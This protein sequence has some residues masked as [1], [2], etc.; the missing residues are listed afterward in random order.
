MSARILIVDDA[1]FVRDLVRRTVR[2][3]L[4]GVELEEAVNGRK[5]SQLMQGKP[6]DLI[7]CDWEMPEMSGIEL[8]KWA[9]AQPAYRSTPFIMVTSR[10]DKGHVV[11]AVQG[12][13]SDYLGKP[14]SPELLLKKIAKAL[15]PGK[16]ASVSGRAAAAPAAAPASDSAALLTG[17]A[18]V[19]ASAPAAAAQAVTPK[20][21]TLAQIRFAEFHLPCIVKAVSLNEMRVVARNNGQ[22]AFPA[23]LAQAAV[24]IES[25]GAHTVQRLNGYVHALQAVD[26]RL[27]TDFISLTIRFVDE[28]PEKLAALSHFIESF[29]A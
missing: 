1:S 16:M 25:D 21:K 19:P 10:G 4:P 9:R 27:D 15:G 7:L 3:Q 20:Q 14:F 22:Q 17:A 5:A 26:K 11:E 18:K 28:D 29:Q 8:L 13:V 2:A 6:F 12:G 23:I 24:D